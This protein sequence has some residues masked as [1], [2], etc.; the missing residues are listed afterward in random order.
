MDL[1]NHLPDRLL[2]AVPKK[3]RL[4]EK[5]CELLKGS[6]I[7]FRRSSRLD[8]ALCTN[9][10]IALIFLPAADIP[11]FVGEG[12]CDLGITGL[13]QIQEADMYDQITDLLDL[14]FGKCKLQLQVPADGP[15]TKP[16]QLVGKKIVSSFTKLAGDFFK[17]LEGK[18]TLST[19]LRYVGG[20]VEAS[21][22]LGVADGIVDLVESGE[23]MR[24]AGL[25]AITTLLET[26]A[27]LICAKEPK[28]PDIVNVVKQ[29]IE[30]ILAAQRYVLCNY[31]TPRSL[32]SEVLKITPG[33]RS[34]T[35]SAL[36]KKEFEV[37]E[38][39]AVSAMVEKAETGNIMDALKKIGASDIL[40]FD[41]GNCRV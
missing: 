18:D 20:S 37:E 15:Y 2:F 23:T 21:C 35:V 34:A 12:N 39:V 4:Y 24:A 31:N 13:D 27:H 17:D 7:Q 16:E 26:S 30:G 25:K 36:E 40:V 6:D 8:I 29:R 22:A 9:L 11:I 3:G 1:V 33:R 38:W 5:C 10:P 41:I 14:Q 19:H 28:F 32:L